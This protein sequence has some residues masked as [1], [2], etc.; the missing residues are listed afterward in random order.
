MLKFRRVAI[1]PLYATGYGAKLFLSPFGIL[2]YRFS[3]LFTDIFCLYDFYGITAAKRFN[4]ILW[5]I[6]LLGYFYITVSFLPEPLNLRFLVI[7]HD[8]SGPFVK[9]RRY[10]SPS[11]LTEKINPLIFVKK[12]SLL[13]KISQ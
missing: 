2:F 7:R 12:I 6:K 13:R 3:A 8:F 9:V 4:G 11:L 10:F 1:P 5:Q